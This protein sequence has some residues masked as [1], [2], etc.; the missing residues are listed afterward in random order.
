MV[1]IEALRKTG[2]VI[3]SSLFS[4]LNTQFQQVFQYLPQNPNDK[5]TYEQC[6]ITS[7]KL[8]SA[9]TYDDFSTFYNQCYTPLLDIINT[10]NSQNTVKANIVVTPPSGSAPHNVTLDARGSTDPS[11]DTIPNGNFYWYFSDVDGVQKT[12]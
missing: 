3:P 12:L 11:Q 7:Q 4:Q 5:L 10:I 9:Y 8:S 1:K 2:T 6:R